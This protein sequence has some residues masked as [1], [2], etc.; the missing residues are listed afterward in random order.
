MA[1]GF[2][3]VAT[4]VNNQGHSKCKNTVYQNRHE[5]RAEPHLTSNPAGGGQGSRGRRGG[6]RLGCL[7]G[8]G[9]NP[10][11]GRPS[12]WGSSRGRRFAFPACRDGAW[13]PGWPASRDALETWTRVPETQVRKTEQASWERVKAVGSCL[14]LGF[15]STFSC[16][17]DR[18]SR[19]CPRL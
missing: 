7:G 17:S 3:A 1:E 12:C 6:G 15:V 10:A 14:P 16:A 5:R 4:A 19:F 2:S 8:D 13:M 9:A 11:R 18:A